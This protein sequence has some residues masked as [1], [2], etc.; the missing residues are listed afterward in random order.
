MTLRPANP[1]LTRN[2]Q[3]G[4]YWYPGELEAALRAVEAEAL[5]M[6]GTGD[7]PEDAGRDPWTGQW[8]NGR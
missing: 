6:R 5:T 2:Q 8:R 1:S 7:L 4:D 3:T